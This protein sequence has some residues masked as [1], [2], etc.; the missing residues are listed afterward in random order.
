[1]E[2]ILSTFPTALEIV[3]LLAFS[4]S[5][6]IAAL[7]KHLDLMGVIVLAITTAC[8]GGI[9]RDILLQNGIPVFFTNYSYI[10]TVCIAIIAALV[11]NKIYSRHATLHK[12]NVS[13]AL[14]VADALG[15]ATFG[16]AAGLMVIEQ[17]GN[18]LTCVFICTI[19]G[20]GGG[21]LR[22]ILVQRM[23]IIFSGTIYAAC[24]I[25]GSIVMY[26]LHTVLTREWITAICFII[27]LGL[28]FLGIF[29]GIGLPKIKYH[30]E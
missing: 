23:P 12:F 13:R 18:M 24:C 28:R 9:L 26:L 10:V 4:V 14:D 16:T 3:G 17:G 21:I 19:T 29:K 20:C 22:D 1:M 2:N 11:F 30:A 7:Q 6:V 27:I 5:G 8:G 15:L 25:S